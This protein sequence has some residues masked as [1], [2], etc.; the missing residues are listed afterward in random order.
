MRVLQ[1]PRHPE[2]DQESPSRLEANN[3]IL[4]AT[5]ERSDALALEAARN[6]RGIRGPGQPR[7]RHL[8]PLEAPPLEQRG[9]LSPDRLDLGQLGHGRR[10]VVPSVSSFVNGRRKPSRTR[11]QGGGVPK[12]TWPSEDD[13]RRRFAAGQAY[14]GT[15]G[16]GH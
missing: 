7:I 15:C 4:A 8:D 2:V 11:P 9:K 16:R 12:G 1:R 13:V 5:A 14:N 10:L 6:R 3:Q